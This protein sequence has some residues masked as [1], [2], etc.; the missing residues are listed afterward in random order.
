MTAGHSSRSPMTSETT[1]PRRLSI[2]CVSPLPPSPPR[3]GVQARMHGLMTHLAKHHDVTAI[4]L[5]DDAFDVEECRR[6]MREYC[7][8]VVLIPNPRAHQ[9]A[10]KRILQ[11]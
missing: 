4:S 2:L 7:A 10:A 5:Y 8:E 1:V 6:A 11:L 3:F 9:S